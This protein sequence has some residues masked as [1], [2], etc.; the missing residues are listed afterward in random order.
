MN[1][2]ELLSRRMNKIIRLRRYAITEKHWHKVSQ[3]DLI[4]KTISERMGELL[5]FNHIFNHTTNDS[6]N[7]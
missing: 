2:L 1:E 4:L 7:N 5:F 3:A 6:N